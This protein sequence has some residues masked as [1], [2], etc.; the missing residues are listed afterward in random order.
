LPIHFADPTLP[1][2]ERPELGFDFRYL[3][4][5]DFFWAS[6]NDPERIA[7]LGRLMGALCVAGLI[8]AVFVFTR[9]RFGDGAG[10]LAAGMTAFTPDVLAHGGVAYNDLPLALGYLL[11]VWAIDVAVRKPGLARGALVGVCFALAMSIKFSAIVIPAVALVLILAQAI[12]DWNWR[13]L[14]RVG[15]AI[16][17][18]SIVTYA[19]L[20]VVYRGDFLLEE[21]RYGIDY[22]FR[23]VSRGHGAPGFLVGDKARQGWWYFYPLAFFYK[24]PAAFHVLLVAGLIGLSRTRFES[25]RALAAS[26]LRVPVLAGA[27]FL[28]ALLRS[29]LVIGFRYALPALPLLWVIAAVGVARLWPAVGR[30][31]R[32]AIAGLTVWMATATLSAYPHFLAYTSEWGGGRDHAYELLVDSSTD[33]GQG[34]LELRKWMNDQSVDRV[35]LSYF[36]SAVPS[37]YGIDYEPLPSFIPL[38]RVGPPPPTPPRYVVISATNLQG[39]YLGSDPFARFRQ[40]EP[41]TVLAQTLLVYRIDESAD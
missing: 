1:A 20:V 29:N 9:N 6:G 35:Y 27:I 28:A 2:V 41:D 38:P 39:V 3:Y 16:V 12:S 19:V 11:A 8:V 4:S 7:F 15:L 5:R 32:F 22:T 14:G 37:G 26:P 13:W 31:P 23:H 34:L 30:V 18:A 17:A 33:W 25:V 40:I 10:I 24:T 21:M 36:G